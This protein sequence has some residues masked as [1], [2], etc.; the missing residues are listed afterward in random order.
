MM[1]TKP[2]WFIDAPHDDKWSAGAAF[3][4]KKD[5]RLKAV[6]GRVG[7]CTLTPHADDFITLCLSIFNQQIAMKTAETLFGRFRSRFPRNKPTPK[8][9]HA[10]LSGEWDQATI[11]HCG[12]SR[13]KH[14]YLIDLSEK[15]MSKFIVPRQLR[16]L[17]D[18]QITERLS[19][20]KGIGKWTAEMFLIFSLNRPDVWP[21][22]DLGLREAVKREFGLAERPAAR[23]L[24]E[25]AEPW[26]PHRTLATWYLWRSITAKTSRD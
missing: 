21:V 12:L 7:P 20:I 19:T 3:L 22:D 18:A 8:L 25:L 24:N 10:A 9:V 6:I 16:E 26:R 13:Q 14:A 23:E 4:A 11:R 1:I 15:F 17:D 2:Q 5:K